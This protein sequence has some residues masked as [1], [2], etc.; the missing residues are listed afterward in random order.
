MERESPPAS[1]AE[2]RNR[3][4]QR[5][6]IDRTLDPQPDP[7]R[8]LDLDYSGIGQVN[9]T[10]LRRDLHGGKSHRCTKPTAPAIQLARMN[11]GF[12][13]NRGNTGARLKGGCH[14]PFLLR[15]TPPSS[16]LNRCDDLNPLVRHVTIPMNSHM[17]H[18]PIK[19]TR[20]PLSDGYEHSRWRGRR[21]GGA[22]DWTRCSRRCVSARVSAQ[23]MEGGGY[24]FN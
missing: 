19:S 1:I 15:R 21:S 13:C 12:P 23:C 16:T 6:C 5:H 18:I 9:W 20:R 7:G 8:K 3:R 22:G 4:R 14:Q 17:T 11:P 2:R 10:C 24:A